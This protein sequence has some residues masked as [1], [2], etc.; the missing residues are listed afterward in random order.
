[1]N[2]LSGVDRVITYPFFFSFFDKWNF[3]L[4]IYFYK[5]EEHGVTKKI[6]WNK[7]VSFL[8]LQFYFIFPFFCAPEKEKLL[9]ID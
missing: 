7:G 3:Y 6:K 1:M 8:P 9:L 2:L 5:F 4:F